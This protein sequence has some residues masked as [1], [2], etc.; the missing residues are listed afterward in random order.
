MFLGQ[1]MLDAWSMVNV[2]PHAAS[3][4]S[5]QPMHRR[6][7]EGKYLC[8]AQPG[9]AEVLGTSGRRF[10]SGRT[11]HWCNRCFGVSAGQV[12]MAKT[13]EVDRASLRRLL[14]RTRDAAYALLARY[15][16]TAKCYP[17]DDKIWRAAD[18]SGFKDYA[19]LRTAL[20]AGKSE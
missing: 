14:E 13:V 3:G 16:R 11:D 8:V 1:P 7:A 2:A 20:S 10:E 12:S 9:S 4:G 19:K 18:P 6:C 17:F 5:M 15:D